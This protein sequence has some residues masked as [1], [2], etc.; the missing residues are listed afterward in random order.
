MNEE[1]EKEIEKA[2]LEM[3]RIDKVIHTKEE[4]LNQLKEERRKTQLHIARIHK[5]EKQRDTR[6]SKKEQTY[7]A[8]YEQHKDFGKSKPPEWM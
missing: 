3:V 7:D 4:E 2:R 1:K 5:I 6:K 8:W